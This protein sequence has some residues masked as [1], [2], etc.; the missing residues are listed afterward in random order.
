MYSKK[1]AIAKFTNLLNRSYKNRVPVELFQIMKYNINRIKASKTRVRH[2]TT[3]IPHFHGYTCNIDNNISTLIKYIWL[4]KIDT[5]NSCENN[6]PDGFI[7]IQFASANDADFFLNIVFNNISTYSNE[8]NRGIRIFKNPLL[9][10]WIYNV[11]IENDNDESNVVNGLSIAISIRFPKTDYDWI[12]EKF[13]NYLVSKHI[14]IDDTYVY[15][16]QIQID[17][18][19]IIT[20]FDNIAYDNVKTGLWNVWIK[21]FN[22]TFNEIIICYCDNDIVE[23]N[24]QD[25]YWDNLEMLDMN[26]ELVIA[27]SLYTKFGKLEKIDLDDQL[28]LF[29]HGLIVDGSFDANRCR[30]CTTGYDYIDGIK[31]VLA[32]E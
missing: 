10:S 12:C 16:G 5:Y 6:I 7:W 4:Y 22:A 20:C 24:E 30:V 8:Y 27:D 23:Y 11:N 13:K 28:K 17:N 26:K 3:R 1:R 32:F 19:I 15:L 29:T 31:I 18:D 21:K 14:P 25:Y 2:E 9:K